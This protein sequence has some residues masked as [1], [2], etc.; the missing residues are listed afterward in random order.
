[1]SQELMAQ[2]LI[3]GRELVA[4]AGR[5][6]ATLIAR[7]DDAAALDGC[8]RAIHTLKGSTGLFDLQP[9]AS[10]LHAAEE[11]LAAIRAGR[12]GQAEDFALVLDA[13][14][15][16]DRWLDALESDGALPADAAAAGRAI[17]ARLRDAAPD[18]QQAEALAPA[19]PGWQ[20]P[21]GF[22]G[23][24]GTAIRYTPRT[25]CYFAGDDPLAIV[26]AAPQLTALSIAPRDAW[27]A[28][29]RYDP[30]ACNL[31]IEAVSTAGRAEVEAAFR[32]VADQ[33]EFAELTAAEPGVAPGGMAT[34]RT[35]RVDAARIDHLGILADELVTAKSGL[36]DLATAAEGLAGGHALGQALRGR[37]A[38]LDRLVRDLHAA[39]GK[40]RLAPLAPL[41]ARFPR[42]A[43][44][45][46]GA[47]GKTVR[48]ELEGQ[49]I[50]V[51]KT[52]VDGLFDPLLHVLRNALDH[53]V[54]PAEQRRSAGKPEA[55]RIRLA[56]RAAG[57]Q[58]VIEVTD[59]GAGIDP[60]RIRNLAVARG[61]I[62]RD[63]ADALDDRDAIDLIFIPGFST[64]TAVNA[65]SGRGVGMDVVR[66]AAARL[67]GKVML[68]GELGRGTTVRFVL[69][70]TMVLAKL[71][72]VASGG[73]RYGLAL[74][75]VVETARIAADRLVAVRSRQ[76]F[77]FRD[78]VVPL[79][80]LQDLV[81]AGAAGGPRGAAER[82]IIARVGGELV[83]FAVDA[84]VDRM[85]AAVRPLDGLLSGAPGLAG[86]TLMPDG[87]VL[88]VLDLAELLP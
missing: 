49:E 78:Q 39:V 79:V 61:V 57:D 24:T 21:A 51:D 52:I 6:L 74:D 69:P 13:V 72:V 26:A 7:H 38:A 37:Q 30:F 73:E 50:E 12:P 40:V 16:V 45:I 3:E 65:V 31:V 80:I 5:D 41:F 56:A 71:M 84:I 77:Q 83:G 87:S 8:F 68:S 34:R 11:L 17:Q 36:A 62:G 18:L 44:E 48:L 66:A 63:A 19:A 29:D 81:G 22:A 85:D 70:M 43:R 25:D 33:V 64:A 75:S 55:G 76:A 28:L 10:M 60:V 67:G 42:L 15:Q 82:V 35:L 23:L 20:L 54:E 14:D 86:S 58:V 46:A 4:E 53:G 32:F 47:L 2:F 9:M 1:M 88:L 27:G 59:D